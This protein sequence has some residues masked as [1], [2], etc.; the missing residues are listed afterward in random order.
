MGIGGGASAGTPG[1]SSYQAGPAQMVFPTGEGSSFGVNV[2]R[3]GTGA[4]SSPLNIT[5]QA[6]GG[7]IRGPGSST[8]DSIL[9]RLSNGE[10]VLNAGSVRRVGVGFLE[11]LNSFAAGGLVSPLPRFAEGGLV[12]GGGTPVHLHLGG[13]SFALSGSESVVG[14]L[15]LEAHRHKIRSAGIK[16]SWYGGTPGR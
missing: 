10:F 14:S 11:A 6:T 2:L 13:H 5:S 15:V 1:T 9:A 8:S 4:P 16:P 7:Y 3:G 12:G